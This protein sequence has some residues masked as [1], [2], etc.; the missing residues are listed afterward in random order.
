M[1]EILG[2]KEV[3]FVGKDAEK[4]QAEPWKDYNSGYD[5]ER[6][7]YDVR[8]H[9]HIAYRYEIID[10]LGKGSFGQ[11]LRCFDHQAGEEVALKI[12]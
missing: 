7:D 5:D 9:D 3:W 11:C 4:V 12:I 6:G 8:L 2:Y 1:A 10:F